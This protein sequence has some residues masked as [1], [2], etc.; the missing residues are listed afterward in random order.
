MTQSR[1]LHRKYARAECF[2]SSMFA[3]Q[4]TSC[5]A[6]G[7]ANRKL[8]LAYPIFLLFRLSL[9]VVTRIGKM[10]LHR[11]ILFLSFIAIFV[12]TYAVLLPRLLPSQ[13]AD[14]TT[15]ARVTDPYVLTTGRVLEM[16]FYFFGIPTTPVDAIISALV[17]R[18]QALANFPG[19]CTFRAWHEGSPGVHIDITPLPP[20]PDVKP[21]SCHEA[22]RV[23]ERVEEV[24]R[25]E[26]R[27]GTV[28]V[29]VEVEGQPL[30][31]A[32]FT[33]RRQN[34]R[35]M[36]SLDVIVSQVHP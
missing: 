15:V 12:H 10:T 8:F 14:K 26:E 34:K 24:L 29:V 25:I 18:R 19:Q 27:I 13:S 4:G 28:R 5:I 1:E 33:G 35:T 22:V 6:S 30:G 2:T 17:R 16:D 36:R 32:V 11:Y 23:I 7:K 31:T 3:K 21:M 9:R 20:P